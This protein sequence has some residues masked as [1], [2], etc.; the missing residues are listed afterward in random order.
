[1]KGTGPNLIKFFF[2]R[3]FFIDWEDLL[4]IDE[5]NADNSTKM[6]L[7]QINMLLDTY[8]PSKIINKYQLKFKSKAWTTLGLQKSKSV[9]N[10]LFTNFI[11]TKEHILKK[12]FH[13][14]CKKFTLHPDDE[15]KQ[16]YYK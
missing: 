16:T 6:Y 15:S 1:M 8:A 2:S 5:L 14:N 13:N 4:K 3:P 9:Q 12:G 10:N 11:N 7:D